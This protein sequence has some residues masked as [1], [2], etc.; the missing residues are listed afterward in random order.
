MSLTPP[1]IRTFLTSTLIFPVVLDTGCNTGFEIDEMHL[2]TW[3]RTQQP[4]FS[5]L[6][7][8]D[9]P[10]THPFEIRAANIWLHLEPYTGP[11]YVGPKM[12]FH[13]MRTD[14]ITVMDRF[15]AEPYPRF[16]LLGLPA[17]VYNN[18]Q[19]MV[20]GYSSRFEIYEA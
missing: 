15:G 11:R 19:V 16:P 1:N 7:R 17:L 13:L 2:I 12:P 5:L 14:Q 9:R 8:H 20:D 6:T 4:S 10:G 3:T 18:L